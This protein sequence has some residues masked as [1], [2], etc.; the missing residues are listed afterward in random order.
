MRKILPIITGL[1]LVLMAMFSCQNEQVTPASPPINDY[2]VSLEQAIESVNTLLGQIDIPTR[3]IGNVRQVAEC[4]AV[5]EAGSTRTSMTRTVDYEEI[6]EPT[7]YVINF[8]DNQGF[9]IVSVNSRTE[10][11]IYAVMD[12]GHLNPQDGI[13][14]PGAA[15]MLAAVK[16]VPVDPYL[17]A[18]GLDPIYYNYGP[19][20][21]TQTWGRRTN[22]RW[23]QREPFN[24]FIKNQYPAGCAY[25]CS[26]IMCVA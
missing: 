9:A 14:N 2:H 16:Y 21:N 7:A 26:I 10:T 6:G 24:K 20:E 8:E 3:G 18:V 23:W 12:Y 13:D 5:G 17:P 15:A 25:R 22:L 4:Y 19:W 1:I 11:D